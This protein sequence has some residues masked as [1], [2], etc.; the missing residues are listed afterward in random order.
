MS[1]WIIKPKDPLIFRDG[2]PFEALPGAT[3][4]SLRFPYPSTTTG[5][6]RTREGL[7][8][9]GIFQTSEIP[10]I[11]QMAVQ[12]PLLV[13]L[14]EADEIRDWLIPSPA[15]ALILQANGHSTLKNKAVVK[16]LVPIKTPNGA[17]T[18]L[19][20]EF[21]L[22]GLQHPI[23]KKPH[24][25]SPLYWSWSQMKRWLLKPEEWTVNLDELGTHGPSLET[26][27]IHV[28]IDPKTGAAK[29]HALFQTQGLEFRTREKQFALVVVTDSKNI[30]PGLAPLGGER[31]L[32][33]WQKSNKRLPEIPKELLASIIKN[34]HCRIILLTP[35]CFDQG[36]KPTWLLR[37]QKGVSSQL[38][39]MAVRRH[40]VVSGWD[41]RGNNGRGC[42]KPTRRL[43]PAGT[44]LFLNLEGTEQAI[45]S[46]CETLWFS[47]ISD[48]E[49]DRRDGFGL[50]LLG[51]WDGINRDMEVK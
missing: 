17:E 26:P 3:A 27:R 11:L 18:D 10:R 23:R 51:N 15:D 37:E 16:N 40:E 36:W 14:D 21:S 32:V 24:S 47:A 8:K 2:K 43:T 31:R 9:D 12:G 46:W 35:A 19:P 34:K 4:Q 22:V 13:E 20:P 5:A 39:A 28:S 48:N 38:R 49:Q 42:P 50:A 30:K 7:D 6:T 29:E 45:K 1:V 33:M 44:V 41:M 25:D